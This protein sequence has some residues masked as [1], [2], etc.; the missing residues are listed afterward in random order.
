MATTP[1]Y[2]FKDQKFLNCRLLNP[3]HFGGNFTRLANNLDQVIA[4]CQ[5]GYIQLL[6]RVAFSNHIYQQLPADAVQT[7]LAE[8]LIAAYHH[9]PGGRIGEDLPSISIKKAV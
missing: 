3:K 9:I 6:F 5:V 8:R 4:G 7:N 1:H 2:Y